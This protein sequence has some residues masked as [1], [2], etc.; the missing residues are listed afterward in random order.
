M[1][2]CHGTTQEEPVKSGHAPRQVQAHEQMAHVVSS[3]VAASREEVLLQLSALAA[4]VLGLAV[5]SNAP[6]MEVC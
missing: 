1:L 5:D 3:K 6:L 4:G 2:H